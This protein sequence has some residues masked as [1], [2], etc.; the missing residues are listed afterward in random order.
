MGLCRDYPYKNY[1]H[2]Y[3]NYAKA[4]IF[5]CYILQ[6]L[7]LSITIITA[8]SYK[9]YGF[10]LQKLLWI[11]LPL[12][13][14]RV[15]LHPLRWKWLKTG[16]FS[17]K[18]LHLLRFRRCLAILTSITVENLSLHLLRGYPYKNYGYA[19]LSLHLLRYYPYKNYGDR[20][21]PPPS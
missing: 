3:K 15:F 18:S 1:Y 12:H 16:G 5:Y 2:P 20:R 8:D 14:L 9:N 10:P 7:L 6:G 19:G 11:N 17:T 13:L 21:S 4:Y